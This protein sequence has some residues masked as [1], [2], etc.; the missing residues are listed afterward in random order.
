MRTNSIEFF[1]MLVEKN[2]Q[3][4]NYYYYYY[5]YY[6]YLSIY[7]LAIIVIII[8]KSKSNYQ[9][10]VMGVAILIMAYFPLM[11]AQSK[12]HFILL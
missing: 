1:I 9:A 12:Y 6:Y 2:K 4:L 7:L 8:M 5:Y 11:S 3:S 10:L